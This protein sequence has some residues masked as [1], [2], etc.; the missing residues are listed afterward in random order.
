M[1][2]PRSLDSHEMVGEDQRYVDQR[3]SYGP[4][5][6]GDNGEWQAQDCCEYRNQRPEWAHQSGHEGA[7]A[8]YCGRNV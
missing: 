2:V 7:Y 8:Q 3:K 5:V 4:Q 6:Y 1:R